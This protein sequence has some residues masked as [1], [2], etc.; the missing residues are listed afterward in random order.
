[1]PPE[2]TP[3]PSP[4]AGS[5]PWETSGG[6][7]QGSWS[8]PFEFPPGSGRYVQSNS[9]TG[10]LKPVDTGG[11]APPSKEPKVP[12][13]GRQY[14][15][16]AQAAY[17]AIQEGRAPSL[18]QAAELLRPAFTAFEDVFFSDPRAG[19]QLGASP[20]LWAWLNATGTADD[21]AK[22]ALFGPGDGGGGGGGL[23]AYQ[24][25]QIEAD[26]RAAERQTKQDRISLLLDQIDAIGGQQS[27]MDNRAVASKKMLLDALG[28]QVPAGQTYF[29]GLGPKSYLV[30]QG[31]TEPVAVV[32]TKFD[33][34]IG[35]NQYDAMLAQRIAELQGMAA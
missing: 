20:S 13:P 9:A 16:P 35:G 34:A 4:V 7:Q 8:Q 17:E 31:L 33:P 22:D 19:A 29:A 2:P 10:E 32:P 30:Q 12:V 28:W 27:A 1:M 24:A 18:S 21:Y 14:P 15:V 11:Y 26:R 5:R 25:Y 6:T 3:T 23:T